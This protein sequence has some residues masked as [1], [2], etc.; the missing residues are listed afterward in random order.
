MSAGDEPKQP[1]RTSSRMRAPSGGQAHADIAP[2][3]STEDDTAL[4]LLAIH[5]E[6]SIGKFDW[7]RI[8]ENMVPQ[9]WSQEQLQ[10]RLMHL[11][12]GD[13]TLLRKLPSNYVAGSSLQ[14]AHSNMAVEEIYK[15]IDKIFGHLTRSDVRQPSGK[16]HLN[17]GELA[18]V[19]VSLMLEELDLSTQDVFLDVGSGIGSVLAQ[20][21]MQ[22]PVFRAIGLEIQ[23]ELA[24]KSREAIR[25]ATNEFQRLHLIHVITGDIKD[26]TPETEKNL[27]TATV[28]YSNNLCFDPADDLY[29][30]EF[31]CKA[32]RLRCVIT[33]KSFCT[34]CTDQCP[35]TF[36]KIWKE[37]KTVNAQVCWTDTPIQLFIYKRAK[38]E[39]LDMVR[40]M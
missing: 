33:S 15:A 20:V 34:R 19:G 28:M 22:S 30:D 23:D 21:V 36:C 39:L 37:T 2:E 8:V 35:K 32:E 18:P 25:E 10:A 7:P 40:N 4:L 29:L 38:E 12:I 3:F 6:D 27:Q 5:F 1:E 26:L 24:K 9:N 16:V 11:K 14:G 13:T 17:A 31:A